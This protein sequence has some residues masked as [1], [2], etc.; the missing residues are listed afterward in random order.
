[1][2]FK[3]L[4]YLFCRPGGKPSC[5]DQPG[6]SAAEP[7]LDRGFPCRD[8]SGDRGLCGL[9]H[10][11]IAVA[12]RQQPRGRLSESS[13]ARSCSSSFSFGPGRRSGHGGSGRPASGCGGT[14]GWGCS[15]FLLIVLHSGFRLGG[16][17]SSVLMI[18]FGIT[19]ASG[20]FGLFVQQFLPR[21][22]LERVPAETIYS[23]ID[24]V[25]EQS[26]WNAEDL[27]EATCGEAIGQETQSLR[28]QPARARS[29]QA[30]CHGEAVR[31]V[32]S[33]RA[34]CSRPK[35][36]RPPRSRAMPS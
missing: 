19:I 25:A 27:I 17:L 10:G 30:I 16:E 35:F 2:T 31:S 15:P 6:K 23:Q 4:F 3:Q 24:Y 12:G 5:V 20:L 28:P 18:L 9:V 34:R 1:M 11:Q 36:P 33:V 21:M 22:M 29:E 7:D 26:Y 14:S 8:S 32:G 13:A